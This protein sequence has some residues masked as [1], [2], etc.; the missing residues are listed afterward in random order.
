MLFSKKTKYKNSAYYKVEAKYCQDGLKLT[1]F[2]PNTNCILFRTFNT[3]S[4]LFQ[5]LA[6][7]CLD[8][9]VP[10]ANATLPDYKATGLDKFY[11]LPAKTWR[12]LCYVHLSIIYD[13]FPTSIKKL[14]P[15]TKKPVANKIVVETK[16]ALAKTREEQL[17]RSKMTEIELQ[18]L[19]ELS[20]DGDDK[21]KSIGH[22]KGI[23]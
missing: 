4:K 3:L 20:I 23:H 22:E 8:I 11:E 7:L 17:R 10:A 16:K 21:F 1:K 13:V 6:N 14:T 15:N 9:R 12:Q 18:E 2:K 5:I 19:S